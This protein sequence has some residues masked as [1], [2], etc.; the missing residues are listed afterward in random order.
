MTVS[1]TLPGGRGTA[2][3]DLVLLTWCAPWLV[4]VPVGA[5]RR[6]VETPTAADGIQHDLA[7]V[8]GLPAGGLGGSWLLID[9][10]PG[11]ALR[12]DRCLQ[13][14]R[15][16]PLHLVPPALQR[17]A[18]A[19]AAFAPPTTIAGLV[20]VPPVGLW[21]DPRQVPVEFRR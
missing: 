4:A 1:V 16:G 9:C 7:T 11:L 14:V 3:D 17:R 21:L 15:S 12:V 10:R 19:L 18:V 8:L 2:G 20:Q 6:I 5:V 13:L